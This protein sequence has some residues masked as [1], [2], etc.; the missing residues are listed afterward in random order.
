[1][2]SIMLYNHLHKFVILN[3]FVR[4]YIWSF[5][6]KCFH[7]LTLYSSVEIVQFKNL[8]KIMRRQDLT[9]F[10][11][12]IQKVRIDLQVE[13]LHRRFHKTFKFTVQIKSF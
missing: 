7:R 10:I 3:L 12:C 9:F 8:D 13:Y 5:V 4:F 11:L 2:Y 1:M 6:I